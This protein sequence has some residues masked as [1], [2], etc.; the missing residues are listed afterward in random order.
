MRRRKDAC[1]TLPG[2][3]QKGPFW[4]LEMIGLA[5]VS[6]VVHEASC[7]LAQYRLLLSNLGW[8]IIILHEEFKEDPDLSLLQ[9][10][11]CCAMQYKNIISL[12]PLAHSNT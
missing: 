10:E 8:N 5:R 12:M 7:W 4:K 6:F 2:P 9:E 3:L 1:L 11:S